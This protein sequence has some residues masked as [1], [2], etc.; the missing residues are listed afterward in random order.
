MGGV[1]GTAIKM[2]IDH[3]GIAVKEMCSGI[4]QWVNIF[5]YHQQTNVTT[6][7]KQKVN[8]VFLEKEG[9]LDIK[10][11]EPIDESSPI[12]QF[13]KRGGGIHHICLKCDDIEEKIDELQKLGCR[14]ITSLQPGEA[15]DNEKF[16]FLYAGNGLNIELI[17]TDKRANRI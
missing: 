12:Y 1:M 14:L 6:N 13:A 3:I 17:Y 15:F 10:L 7:K 11:I 4:N 5:G 2:I 9:S 16:A 8:I